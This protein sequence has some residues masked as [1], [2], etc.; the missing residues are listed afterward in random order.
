MPYDLKKEKM[1]DP[2]F[3]NSVV[4]QIAK[5]MHPAGSGVYLYCSDT[6][7]LLPAAEYNL[8]ASLQ[9]SQLPQQMFES[10]KLVRKRRTG[11]PSLIAAPLIQFD[12]P[13]GVL[14]AAD[15]NSDR[16][17]SDRDIDLILSMA[18][19]VAMVLHQ[20]KRLLRMTA[21]FR[22]LHDI[23]IALSS[24]LELDRV[25]V[26]ILE[27]AVDLVGAESGSLRQIKRSSGKL[28]LKA[29]LG[30]GWTLEALAFIPK[31][32]IVRWVAEHKCSYL[33]SDL[34]KDPQNIVLFE[35][36]KSSV[37]VPL[38][39][40]RKNVAT[41]ELLGVLL[42]ESSKLAAFDQQ[43]VE[44]LEALAQ[45]SVIAIQNAT[46]HQELRLMH[47]KYE[48]EQERRVAAEK[49]A[50]MGQAATALAHRINNIMGIVPASTAEIDRT[51]KKVSIPLSDRNW[52]KEN[53]ERIERNSRFILKLSDALF[54]PF[55]ES[56]P[57]IRFNMNLLLNEALES[58]DLP[59]DIQVNAEFAHTLPEVESNSL[60]VDIF[61]ELFTNA[62][63]AMQGLGVK[64]LIIRTRTDSDEDGVWVT[65]EISDTGCGIQP[66]KMEHL[67]GMFKLSR[68][69]LGFGLW[70]LRTFIER[71]GGTV[72]CKSTPDK[73]STFTVRLPA[74]C[75]ELKKAG[76]QTKEQK[77]GF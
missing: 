37:T 43:D 49:W 28:E 24:S 74:F 41:D 62:K 18:D 63:K 31:K 40:R 42:L 15:E 75:D 53:L 39:I 1:F 34:S 29:H 70:W 65:V 67:W 59:K 4:K 46:Q 55:K 76:N 25:L 8:P 14:L 69:G 12:I 45:E 44:L 7:K 13:L 54:K 57:S 47:K 71:Q 17:F 19:H 16:L 26:L 22:A 51:L 77:S 3:L 23:D 2:A 50:V 68:G 36:M 21:Q 72:E 64:R 10:R 48:Q 20:A 66:E 6:K 60:L 33:C 56:G 35:G 11:H 73:G 38:L 61:V 58:A 9:D 27:K 30:A 52:I 5:L 32:G